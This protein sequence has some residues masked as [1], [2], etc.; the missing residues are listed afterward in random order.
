[1]P[2]YLHLKFLIMVDAK[3]FVA[4]FEQKE[5]VVVQFLEPYVF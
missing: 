1:M 3:E 4:N 5:L 2:R